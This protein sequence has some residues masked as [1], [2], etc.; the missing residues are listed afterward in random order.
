MKCRGTRE[1][2]CDTTR[3]NVFGLVNK[4]LV[5]TSRKWETL[6]NYKKSIAKAFKPFWEN[7]KTLVFVWKSIS[8]PGLQTF[9][10]LPNGARF[11]HNYCELSVCISKLGFPKINQNQCY[12]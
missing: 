2:H 3:W 12:Q 11:V 4:D 7:P 9:V 8:T 6:F 10:C 1:I 5:F